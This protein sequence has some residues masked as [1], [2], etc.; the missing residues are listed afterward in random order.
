MKLCCCIRVLL[1]ISLTLKVNNLKMNLI[2]CFALIY[3]FANKL[4]INLF[5]ISNI[6]ITS[7]KISFISF[8][9]YLPGPSVLMLEQSK[10]RQTPSFLFVNSIK[11]PLIQSTDNG[12][13]FLVSLIQTPSRIFRTLADETLTGKIFKIFVCGR[14]VFQFF[15]SG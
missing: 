1:S 3:S 2:S 9:P 13:Y 12:I 15:F 11:S 4:V 8:C 10:V 5:I 14:I 6:I 7:L